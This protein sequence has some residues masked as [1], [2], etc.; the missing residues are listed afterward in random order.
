VV[1]DE[2]ANDDLKKSALTLSKPTGVKLN[3]FT[4]EKALAKTVAA[5]A[6]S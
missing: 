5:A 4:L 2:A 3:I 6:T 1:D